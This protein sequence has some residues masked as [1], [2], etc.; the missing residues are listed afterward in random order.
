MRGAGR[1]AVPIGRR[2]ADRDIGL[3]G[4]RT[5]RG[6]SPCLTRPRSLPLEGG[7]QGGKEVPVFDRPPARGGRALLPR[8]VV[9]R[10]DHAELLQLRDAVPVGRPRSP[11]SRWGSP[12]SDG[13]TARTAHGVLQQPVK[14]WQTE[15]IE[16]WRAIQ[17]DGD[18]CPRPARG[19]TLPARAR[20]FP[21]RGGHGSGGLGGLRV[22]GRRR[23]VRALPG[24]AGSRSRPKCRGG[25][26]R[27]A[28]PAAGP[29][30]YARARPG[31]SSG[32]RS[33]G[34]RRVQL[35]VA[36]MSVSGI[37]EPWMPPV[38]RRGRWTVAIRSRPEASRTRSWEAS[39]LRSETTVRR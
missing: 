36:S 31:R 26:R 38:T 11:G 18:L 33:P 7:V 28:R 15:L 10:P 2:A 3:S 32:C 39:C 1:G 13:N 6:S 14:D 8:G 29:G 16:C 9:V 35:W 5:D 25:R 20:A 21:G 34:R 22:R 37:Q 17:P 19:A 12:E 23:E 4:G 30:P 24:C 27:A